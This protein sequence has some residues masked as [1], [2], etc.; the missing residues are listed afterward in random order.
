[1]SFQRRTTI[2][3]IPFANSAA[4]A[5]RTSRSPSFSRR[6]ISTSSGARSA[7]LRSVRSARATCSA[8]P[9]RPSA[10]GVGAVAERARRAGDV[11]GGAAQDLGQGDG[12]LHRRL[13]VV[14]AQPVGGLLGVID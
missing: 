9:T 13:D 5:S 4:T 10:G 7:P 8:G 1:M 14:Q 6:W 12:L 3:S 11:L 2:G